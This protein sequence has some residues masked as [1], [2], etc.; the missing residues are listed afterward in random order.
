MNPGEVS[1]G[2]LFVVGTPIG[3]LADITHRAV[4]TL[5]DVDAIVAEDSR[6]SRRILEHYDID[7][8]FTLSYYQGAGED[9]R[10]E[11][12]EKLLD[13]YD[14][15]LISDAG[16]PLISDPGFKL[17]REVRKKGIEVVGIPGPNAAIT[18]LSIS[19]QPTDSFTFDGQAPKKEGRKRKYFKQ[20]RT[21]TGTTV[22]YDSPH[23]IETTLELL[24]ETLSER[25]ITLCR[26]LTKEFEQT[27]KG[28]PAEVLESLGEDE[29]KG[30][31]TIVIRGA[32]E[33]EAARARREEYEDVPIEDQYE[34]L[35]KLKGLSRKEAMKELARIRGVSKRDI[36]E[37]LNK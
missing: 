31:F 23:R 9:R 34:G 25:S 19:G 18:C 24:D 33:E 27:I 37:K 17:V 30:E 28:T 29:L 10:E 12:I 1:P 16:T 35:K 21:R 7:T 11:L 26:E 6:H 13:G 8:P 15:A 20:L 14:L 4:E 2:K 22:I 3:N 5:R 32:T 36:Y